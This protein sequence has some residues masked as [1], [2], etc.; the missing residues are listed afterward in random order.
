MIRVE[1]GVIATGAKEK[2]TPELLNCASISKANDLSQSDLTF[3]NFGNP[4]EKYSVLLDG[5]VLPIPENT[6]NENIGVWSNYTSNA[7]GDFIYGLPTVTLTSNELFSVEGLGLVFDTK[8][9]IYPNNFSISWYNGESIVT[10]KEYQTNSPSFSLLENIENFDKIVITFSK[11]NTPYSRLKLHSIQYGSIL[12]IEEKSIKNMRLHQATS[13]ISTTI[14]TSNLQLVFLN[15]ENANYNFTARQSLKVYDNDTL[16]GKYFI[17]TSKQANR[18]QWNITAQDYINILEG[19]EFEGG[20]YVDE[21]ATDILRVIFNK[22]NVPFT[23]STELEDKIVTGYIPY[24]TCRKALQQVLFAIGAYANTSY[25]ENVDILAL[26]T[27]VT[28]SISLN[29]IMVGQMVSI[30]A[31]VTEIELFG[32]NYTPSNNETVLYN[33]KESIE[34]TKI[35]FYEPVYDLTIE[36]G[37]ILESGTNYA[38]INCGANG[39][40]KGKKFEHSTFSKS[41]YNTNAK[42]AKTTNKKTIKTATLISSSNIDNILEICYNYIVKNIEVKSKVIETETRLIV[43]KTYEVETELLG[44]VTGFLNEQNFSLYGGRKIV[45]ETVIK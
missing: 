6:E 30:D 10:T 37:E 42:N 14:P 36:N 17:E 22:A 4:C 44:K 12:I 26:D 45:K 19:T 9:N 32:H 16:I 29:K 23:I 13:A 18:Q 28:E 3:K 2:F 31:D 5:G 35:I 25:S 8:N 40:L 39:I 24:S 33:S 34:D 41:L 43:G 7:S 11:M 15:A 38:V 21:L 1:Y 27:T 20:I